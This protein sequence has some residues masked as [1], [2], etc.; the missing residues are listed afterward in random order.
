MPDEPNTHPPESGALTLTLEE[1]RLLKR[2]LLKLPASM[3]GVAGAM[4]AFEIYCAAS[5][6][7][8]S[9]VTAANAFRGLMAKLEQVRTCDDPTCTTCTTCT[10]SDHD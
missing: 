8:A 4:A 7:D 5:D 9:L 10:V 3:I 2:T 1:V 6:D